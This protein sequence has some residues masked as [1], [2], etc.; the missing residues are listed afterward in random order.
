ML[1]DRAKAVAVSLG[2]L[3]GNLSNL[4]NCA[5]EMDLTAPWFFE[6]VF[7]KLKI[8]GLLRTWDLSF[9]RSSMYDLYTLLVLV[10]S[11]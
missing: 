1:Q 7:S 8:S 5:V 6:F 11:V 2:M 4:V 9:A 3:N 10:F